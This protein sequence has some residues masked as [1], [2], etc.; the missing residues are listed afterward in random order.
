MQLR[1]AWE[2]V[3]MEKYIFIKG[4]NQFIKTGGVI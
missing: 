1:S 4:F 3:A 2:I